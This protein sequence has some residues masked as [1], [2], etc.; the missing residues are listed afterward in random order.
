MAIKNLPRLFKSLNVTY[1][2][3][4]HFR[5]NCL[6]GFCKASA[7]DK[8]FEYFSY[9]RVKVKI[10]SEKGKWLKFHDGQYQFR[11]PFGSYV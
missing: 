3:T 8:K 4:I 11:V 1:K 6:N 2:K 10:T 5:M 9:A 7:R